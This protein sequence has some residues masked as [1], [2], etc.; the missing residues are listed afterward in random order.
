M[1]IQ[2]LMNISSLSISR[3]FDLTFLIS[4]H[5]LPWWR[6]IN[7]F[8]STLSASSHMMLLS[9]T[10]NVRQKPEK[11]ISSF[12]LET[13]FKASD[14][15]KKKGNIWTQFQTQWILLTF[16]NMHICCHRRR[17]P[18]PQPARLIQHVNIQQTVGNFTSTGSTR[19]TFA[20]YKLIKVIFPQEKKEEEK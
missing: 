7:F 3:K 8:S 16:F 4:I 13:Y 11:S 9:S 20:I 17:R 1:K 5:R 14:T 15:R 6:R 2:L 18:H 10:R 12:S 19:Y